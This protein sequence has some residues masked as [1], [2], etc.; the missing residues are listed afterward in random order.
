MPLQDRY[1][2]PAFLLAMVLVAGC[3]SATQTPPP[4]ATSGA[5]ETMEVA[6]TPVDPSPTPVFASSA[7]QLIR[8]A[9]DFPL[10]SPDGSTL[11][12]TVPGGEGDTDELVF[13]TSEGRLLR[14]IRDVRAG[15]QMQWLP[16][17]SGVFVEVATEQRAGPL[18][19][20]SVDGGVLDTGLEYANPALA[21][22]GK[23]IAA[24]HHEGCC[25]AVR[26]REIW[27]APRS[28]GAPHVLATSATA[29]D[30]QQPIALLGWDAQDGVLY[31][32]GDAVWRAAL[33]GTRT[34][35]ALPPSA[36]GRALTKAGTS[37]D[38][39][40]LLVCATD[41]LAWWTVANGMV[42]A[43]PPAMR[44]A[45][46]LRGA[47]CSRSNEVPWYQEHELVLKD[48]AGKLH[49][50]D[51]AWDRDRPISILPSDAVL[52][53]SIGTFLVSSG[54][55]VW[56][57]HSLGGLP[58][59]LSQAD[60]EVWPVAKGAF[61]VRDGAKSYLVRMPLNGTRDGSWQAAPEI[62]YPRPLVGDNLVRCGLIAGKLTRPGE[63][64]GATV[65]EP[66]VSAAF[67]VTHGTLVGLPDDAPSTGAY[68]CLRARPGA[69]MSGFGGW[70]RP[71]DPD[72]LPRSALTPT[73]FV[74]PP[75]CTY[76]GD[77]TAVPQR[78]EVLWRVACASAS[79]TRAALSPALLEQGWSRCGSD[80]G[81]AIWT[82][83]ERTLTITEPG[84]EV[85]SATISLRA[86]SN[87]P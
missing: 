43:L 78:D 53:A 65:I 7:A 15:G 57:T 8:A 39:A 64:M 22:D 76:A 30:V 10:L 61:F 14:R 85:P 51:A 33:D 13:E 11:I 3:T 50:F 1:G 34:A 16:D 31:R 74:L 70:V 6:V 72:Y 18:V 67:G 27:V 60:V 75:P 66:V 9:G 47:S 77:P 35:L 58:V 59:G 20:V 4:P 71:G 12:S 21:P 44:P 17:S 86:N 52:G 79:D 25:A 81:V 36:R 2:V 69:P 28:G 26:V 48:V 55:T 56:I 5:S 42:A 29:Q 23:W 82:K 40:V 62:R 24:E 73:G 37:P 87:C 63:G 84:G 46:R 19:I 49:L 54:Q 45:W 32:D 80:L 83:D 68:V 38:H 41:P